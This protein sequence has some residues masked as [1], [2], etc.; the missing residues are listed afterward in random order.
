MG[1]GA[2]CGASPGLLG[3]LS[4]PLPDPGG[5]KFVDPEA[6]Q[7]PPDVCE[8]DLVACEG[9]ALHPGFFVP[10]PMIR[11]LG[12]CRNG[13]RVDIA[14]AADFA[15]EV[16]P[17]SLRFFLQLKKFLPPPSGRRIAVVQDV[18]RVHDDRAASTR[19]GPR[20]L[21]QADREIHR[22]LPTHSAEPQ[23]IKPL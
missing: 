20:S 18:A 13:P 17:A 19:P 9:I 16:A 11:R 22:V 10:E 15:D 7:R 6:A 3:N 4:V 12:D 2:V 5:R 14:A 8:G 23:K 1:L 21:S